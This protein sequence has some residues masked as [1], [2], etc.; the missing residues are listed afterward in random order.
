MRSWTDTDPFAYGKKTE[1]DLRVSLIYL[2]SSFFFLIIFLLFAFSL[3]LLR[4]CE[5]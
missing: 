2:V 5:H 3:L 4:P 1:I